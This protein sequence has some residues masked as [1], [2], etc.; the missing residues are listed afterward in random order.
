MKPKNNDGDGTWGELIGMSLMLIG[1][2]TMLCI[3]YKLLCGALLY[4]A[5][6][7]L[8][9]D[10]PQTKPENHLTRDPDKG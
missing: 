10:K 4:F 9:K 6:Y 7:V 8:L 2:L 5:G 1:V 3:D